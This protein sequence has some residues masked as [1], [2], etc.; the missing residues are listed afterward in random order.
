MN[1]DTVTGGPLAGVR[2]AD[3]TW[4]WAGPTST[5]QLAL[6]GADVIK[7]ESP[8]RMD[9]I[10][11]LPPYADGIAG[12]NRSGYF[13]QYNQGKRSIALNLKQPEALQ[14]AKDLVAVS[15]VVTENFAAG[16]MDRLGLGYEGLREIKPDLVMI[17]YSGYGASG[18]KASYVAYGPVQ[19]PMIGL[20]SL[21]GY[22]GLGPSEV[23]LSYG[24]P[25]AGLHAAL[26][27]LAA[28]WHKRRT[29]EGQYID[30]S[31]WEAAIGLSAEGLMSH[32]INGQ[33]PA[34]QGNRDLL[35][36]PQ[37]VFPCQ[38]EDEWVAISC[39][40]DEQWR[41]LCT[42]LTRHDLV[43]D[44]DLATAQ[45]RKR[46]EQELE[47]A[48]TAWTRE[49]PWAE[50]VRLLQARSVPSYHVLSNQGVAEDEQLNALGVFTEIEHPEVGVRRHVGAPWR[51]GG[52]DLGID[53]C[54]PLLGQHTNEVLRDVLRYDEARI[55]ALIQSGACV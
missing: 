9:T 18:P 20:A 41:G 25:N 12:T 29:G 47:A 27:V 6:M 46:R 11:R 49:R 53:R 23:G 37:G 2:V 48:I 8:R 21:S 5:L 4:V 45:G 22:Q 43:E 13:N 36:A 35:E 38:G 16:V 24:D 19:V 1:T 31:Q 32:V 33:Q 7:V 42:V 34:R 28:L 50:V 44:T 40:Q 54:A 51:F 10:R 26:A 39:W 52:S 14:A 30:M 17:S 15:D 3:F 55:A